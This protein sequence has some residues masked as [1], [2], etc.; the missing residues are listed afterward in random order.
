MTMDIQSI[1]AI[2]AK[3]NELHNLYL[4]EPTSTDSQAACIQWTHQLIQTFID[5]SNTPKKALNHPDVLVLGQTV[6][7]KKYTMED[8]EQIF[9]FTH[10]RAQEYSRKLLIIEKASALSDTHI[11]K[12][13]KTF[14]E[15]PI[16]LTIFLVNSARHHLMD[17]LYSRS[18]QIRVPI[19][20]NDETPAHDLES[21]IPLDFAN[22]AQK[23]TK[24]QVTISE[25]TSYL[26]N[27]VAQENIKIETAQY[28][29]DTLSQLEEDMLFHNSHNAQLYKLHACFTQLNA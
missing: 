2:K 21:Y 27:K 16:A 29:Q 13:L 17:T 19:Q 23:I 6:E 20:K 4:I 15:P 1:L 18:I 12:L 5:Q 22:F 14:E 11:N 3:K 25:L 24:D 7:N 26:L 8:I 28:I 10:Y 9:A